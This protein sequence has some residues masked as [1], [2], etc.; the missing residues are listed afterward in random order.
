MLRFDKVSSNEG[1]NPAKEYTVPENATHF[2]LRNGKIAFFLSPN[3]E[4][5]YKSSRH[6]FFIR[7]PDGAK[8]LMFP[9]LVRSSRGWDYGI[10]SACNYKRIDG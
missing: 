7:I 4:D 1:I 6:W 3:G 5:L 8:A 2:G 9:D 10:A